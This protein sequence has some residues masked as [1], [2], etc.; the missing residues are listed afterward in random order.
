MALFM[1][2]ASYGGV[3]FWVSSMSGR[4]GREIIVK[5]PSRGDVHVLQDRG[6]RHRSLQCE[7]LFCDEPDRDPPV[8]RFLEF[9]RLAES[10]EPQIFRHPLDGSYRARVSDLEYTIRADDREITA[11]CTFLADGEPLTVINAGLAGAPLAG[12]E[13][14]SATVASTNTLLA[15]QE[16]TS[17]VPQSTLDTVTAWT[18]AET[19][20]T[21]AVHLE[22][23]SLAQR[24]GEETTR[25]ELIADLERWPIYRA[26]VQLNFEMRRAADAVTSETDDVFEI[27]VDAAQPLRLLCAR[28]YG[29]AFA[30]DKARQ[31]VQLNGIRT[32]GLVPAGTRLTAPR[33]G[34]R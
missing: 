23:A 28:L 13:Q 3:A 34:V 26:F 18:Q 11:S 2:A 24:I 21:R 7:L 27:L 8:D 25:L 14:V 16:M 4:V 12:V 9:R 10:P 19:P 30:E 6:L 32:P 1:M 17:D 5:S 15:E 31:I 22:A 20:D 33:E 29:A